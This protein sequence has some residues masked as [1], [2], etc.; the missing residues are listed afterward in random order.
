MKALAI[1]TGML[2]ILMISQLA[3]QRGGIMHGGVGRVPGGLGRANVTSPAFRSAFPFFWAANGGLASYSSR[4]WRGGNY[5]RSGYGGSYWGYSPY[6]GTPHCWSPIMGT[7]IL[8]GIPSR[9][10]PCFWNRRSRLSRRPLPRP[11]HRFDRQSASI[12]GNRLITIPTR[13]HFRLSR[14]TA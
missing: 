2:G 11:L 13:R 3:A 14:K 4:G 12:N 5:G 6:W 1:R 9:R 7:M 10:R 8:Q